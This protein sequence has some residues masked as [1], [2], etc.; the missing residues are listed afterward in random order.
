MPPEGQEPRV[1]SGGYLST[2]PQHGAEPHLRRKESVA[3]MTFGGLAYIL[4]VSHNARDIMDKGSKS[5]SLRWLHPLH[6]T[7]LAVSGSNPTSAQACH[8]SAVLTQLPIAHCGA[9]FGP[10]LPHYRW[11]GKWNTRPLD[12]CRDHYVHLCCYSMCKWGTGK[13]FDHEEI[14]AKDPYSY[15]AILFPLY[16]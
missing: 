16:S 11:W 12:H 8:L 5:H 9:Q 6:I 2:I 15:S 4:A 10:L 3:R 14:P 7:S 1:L 13:E